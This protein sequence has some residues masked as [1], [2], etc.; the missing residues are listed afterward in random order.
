MFS[1]CRIVTR[2]FSPNNWRAGTISMMTIAKPP[3]T[4]P[5]TKYGG[6]IV[7]CQPGTCDTAK[8]KLTTEWTLSTSGVA[9]AASSMYAFSYRIQCRAE[10]F[11]PRAAIPYAS[12]RHFDL[13]RSRSV[14]KSGI[15]PM[16]Q[17]SS[18]TLA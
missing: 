12:C 17:N 16:Y 8:S 10:P 14:A 1:R 7:V 4:A 11:Q 18:D 13:A 5:A 15:M 6:K 3:N 9:S 2:S